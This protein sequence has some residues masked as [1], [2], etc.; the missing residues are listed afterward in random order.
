MVEIKEKDLV[1]SF[2]DEWEVSKYDEWAFYRNRLNKMNA[3]GVDIVAIRES[4]L[5]LIEIKDYTHP[6][7]KRIPFDTLPLEIAQKCLDTLGGLV[8]AREW[9][10]GDE[11]AFA[12][13]ALRATRVKVIFHV[14]LPPSK[15]GRLSN[16]NGVLANFKD[17][18]GSKVRGIDPH[19]I[20]ESPSSPTDLW[21]FRH[22]KTIK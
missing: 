22:F 3:K 15:G 8:A 5:Y 21:S 4:I 7:S 2:E 14:H 1:F 19:F 13:I 12:V 18:I 16:A 6:N 9:A 10:V 20:V 17:S 11:Q